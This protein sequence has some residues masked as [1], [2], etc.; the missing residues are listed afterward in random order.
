MGA[1]PWDANEI[2]GREFDC[3]A[4][5]ALHANEHRARVFSYYVAADLLAFAG[6]LAVW[7]R[8]CRD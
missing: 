2:L 3:A 1:A 4:Q 6:Q 7:F 8:A 5:T